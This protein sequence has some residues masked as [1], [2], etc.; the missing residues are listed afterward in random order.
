[1]FVHDGEENIPIDS[2]P[3]VA[4]LGWRHGLLDAVKEA[5]SVGVNQVRGTLQNK[6][7]CGMGV[8]LEMACWMR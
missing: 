3:G 7:C 5:R 4:R 1:M 2:M 8:G 6:C